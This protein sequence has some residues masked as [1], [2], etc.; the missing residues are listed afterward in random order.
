[1]RQ[2]LSDEFTCRGHSDPSD[3][4]SSNANTRIHLSCLI[5][6]LACVLGLLS[7][8][9]FKRGGLLGYAS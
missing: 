6:A 3:L 2:R 8:D 4:I 7:A 1:M 9:A 5:D